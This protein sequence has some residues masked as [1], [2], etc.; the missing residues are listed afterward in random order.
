MTNTSSSS[1]T[2]SPTV[3]LVHGGWADGYSWHKVITALQHAGTTVIAAPIPMTSLPDDVAAVSRAIDRVDGPVVLAGHAYAGAVIGAST[4]PEIKA[5]VYIAA[6]APDEGETV[7]EVF[8]RKPPH[9]QAPELTPDADGFMWLPTS[10]FGAA[11]AQHATAEEHA[12]LAAVQ[13]PLHG[14]CITVPVPPPLWKQVPTWYLRAEEDRMIDP[15]T[16]AFMA[17]RMSAEVQSHSVDH[18]P[19]ITAPEL[20]TEIITAAIDHVLV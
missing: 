2:S 19:M 5:L 20:V 8:T 6:L 14:H 16:Q 15:D 10:A 18:T 4:R 17:E 3:V 11:F 9:P 13:R 7:A 1:S 12:L